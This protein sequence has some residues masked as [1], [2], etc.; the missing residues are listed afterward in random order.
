MT[1]Q[2]TLG[3]TEAVQA[4]RRYESG[5]TSLRTPLTANCACAPG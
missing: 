3:A 1:F 4:L 5:G 2:P